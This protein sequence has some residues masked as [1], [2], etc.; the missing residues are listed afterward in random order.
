MIF[1]KGFGRKWA[2]PNLKVTSGLSPGGTK[3]KYEKP[4]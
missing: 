2:W 1:W 3:E 4:Q